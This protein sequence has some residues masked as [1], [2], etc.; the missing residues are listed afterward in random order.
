MLRLATTF[1][2]MATVPA[3]IYAVDGQILI[4]QAAVNTAGGFPYTISQA[5][6][7]KL[8]GNLVVPDANTTAII[9]AHDFVTLD[10]GGF[11]IIGPN[12]CSSGTCS[13]SGNGIGI[14]T[15]NVVPYFNITIRNGAV[16]G[17]GSYGILLGGDSMLVEYIHA[18][19]NGDDGISFIDFVGQPSLLQTVE[20]CNAELNST[21]IG[22]IGGQMNFNNSSR[23]RV[24]GLGVAGGNV[25]VYH[26]VVSGN[27]ALGLTA[28][29]NGTAVYSDNIFKDNGSGSVGSQ[30][31][32]L[33]V[34][35]G[36]NLCGTS[37]CP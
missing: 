29:N 25:A 2:A 21:G 35:M 5:G 14:R 27:V 26:N 19:S 34:N 18:R 30:L 7:Y 6:S 23:N 10:L 37:V 28:Q 8:S 24:Y 36:R 11:S 12:N 9:I 20:H 4:N 22:V 16:Q 1:L 32:G 31:G 13:V 15:L 33:L 17:M 3:C